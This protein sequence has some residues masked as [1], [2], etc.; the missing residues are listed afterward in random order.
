MVPGRLPDGGWAGLGLAAA[1]AGGRVGGSAQRV[2]AVAPTAGIM[3]RLGGTCA[4]RVV[5]LTV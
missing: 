1:V 3:I 2:L 5:A 4:Q